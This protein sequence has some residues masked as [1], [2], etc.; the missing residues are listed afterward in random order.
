[1]ELVDR[2]FAPL[3]LVGLIVAALAGFLIGAQGGST[4]AASTP[5]AAA[6]RLHQPLV[7]SRVTL[8]APANWRAVNGASS[9]PG[10][11]L[12]QTR[13]LSPVG[14]GGGAKLLVGLAGPGSPA[15]LPPGFALS[16]VPLAEVVQLP[17]AEAF[18]YANLAVEGYDGLLTL[19]ALPLPGE[20]TTVIACEAP[21]GGASF[22]RECEQAAAS[23]RPAGQ[24]AAV[25][26]TPS[27]A[28]GRALTTTIAALEQQRSALRARLHAAPG[29]ATA[30]AARQ[31]AAA[32]ATASA[33]VSHLEAPAPASDAQAALASSL[34][35]D[36]TSYR[37]LAAAVGEAATY[38]AA[39]AQ[40]ASTERATDFAL[41]TYALLGY[42]FSH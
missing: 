10:L 38:E 9:V 24:A 37:A 32:F 33:A 13:A 27:A 42:R 34:L 7:T 40:V 17:Q 18:R 15:P 16:R 8:E 11:A 14:G 4:P 1:M 31:L 2:F 19:Y 28:Y 20:G 5:P 35:A 3:A 39:R 6:V 36:A 25:N 23:V 22:I 26:L 21:A 30:G 41:S 29:G 12:T